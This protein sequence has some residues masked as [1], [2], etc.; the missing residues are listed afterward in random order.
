MGGQRRDWLAGM[1]GQRRDW[2]A[3]PLGEANGGG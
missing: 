3:W 1:G 2:L